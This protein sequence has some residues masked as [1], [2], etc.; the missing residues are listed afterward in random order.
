MRSF[1]RTTYRK[2]LGAIAGTI[3]LGALGSGLWD[4]AFKPVLGSTRDIVL[5][6]LSFGI[7][8][9]KNST[10]AQ[11]AKDFHEEASMNV[12]FFIILAFTFVG[13]GLVIIGFYQRRL[14]KKSSKGLEN[15]LAKLK[16][17]DSSGSL[18]LERTRKELISEGEDLIRRSSRRGL[19]VGLWASTIILV[20]GLSIIVSDFVR[21][22][23][24]NSAISYYHQLESISTPFMDQSERLS[25]RG[26][27]SQIKSRQDYA[28]IIQRLQTVAKE[29]GQSVPE[30]NI[31]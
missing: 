30:F 23:Y 4:I 29:N 9:I 10:Y 11:I 21:F 25:I 26:K 12:L 6:L 24:A 20:F 22:S 19:E 5:N 17:P 18:D 28:A 15:T 27:F 14:L 31:W 16:A 8:S 13:I 1:F 2:I 7:A 3:V